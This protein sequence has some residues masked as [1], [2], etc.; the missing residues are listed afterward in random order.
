[1]NSQRTKPYAET[2]LATFV[3]RRV[4][5]LRPR[6]SQI[7]IAAEVGWRSLNLLSMIG[8]GSSKLPVDRVPKLAAALEVDRVYL[9]RLALDQHDSL[10][11]EIIEEA[12]GLAL[13]ENEKKIIQLYRD[14]SENRD[15]APTAKLV[16]ALREVLG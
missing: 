11:W 14:I 2:Q 12:C 1:M 4:L 3:K 5:E 16:R 10:L 9:L 6:K 7:E 8:S 13:S 15:P